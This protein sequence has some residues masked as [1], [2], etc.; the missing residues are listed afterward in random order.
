MKNI[1]PVWLLWVPPFGSSLLPVAQKL[2]LGPGG[3]SHMKQTGM[4]IVSLRGVKFGFWSRL[5]CSGQSADIL[6]RQ[7]LV[8]G[9]AKKGR[10]TRR[11]TEVKFSFQIK[12]FDDYVFISLK[13]TS[14]FICVFLSGLFL[15]GQNLLKP[16]PDWSPLGITKSLS[17]A[18]MV[19]F[20]AGFH[21]RRGRSRSRSHKR[22]YD[23][24]KIENRSRKQ[25]HKLDGIGVGRIRTFP[26]L[27]IPFTTSSF[28]IQ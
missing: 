24:V 10:I 4:L 2:I 21:Q 26:F 22:P 9:S 1:W 14:C 25:S 18:Q 3:N 16:H 7:G 20:K 17:H 5:G 28:M 8:Q 11:E 13:L 23:L 27:P 6:C 15:W 12:A 19:F